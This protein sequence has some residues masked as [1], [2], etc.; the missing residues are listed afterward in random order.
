MVVS[1]YAW[2]SAGIVPDLVERMERFSPPD[3]RRPGRR[4]GN[5]VESCVAHFPY[6][7]KLQE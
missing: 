4:T 3:A 6:A 7:H 5:G 2:D 1:I